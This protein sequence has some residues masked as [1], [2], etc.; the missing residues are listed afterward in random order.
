MENICPKKIS[1]FY[2]YKRLFA[3]L[4]KMLLKKKNAYV[5]SIT[6][7]E[8]EYTFSEMNVLLFSLDRAELIPL[9]ME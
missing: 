9:L 3:E 6:F 2:K 1:F 8:L 4:Y 5:Y 7:E